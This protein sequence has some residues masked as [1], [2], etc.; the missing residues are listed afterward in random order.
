MNIFLKELHSSSDEASNCITLP[1]RRGRVS[2]ITCPRSL[3]LMKPIF[4]A[5]FTL[6]SFWIFS[7]IFLVI[8]LLP[9]FRTSRL[10]LI[11]ISNTIDLIKNK[12][13]SNRSE[14]KGNFVTPIHFSANLMSA[15]KLTSASKQFGYSGIQIM[16]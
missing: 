16:E 13:P 11:S 1:G 2:C 9:R 4:H 3:Y 5:R 14:R 7:R 8:H 10:L 6:L 12:C 15:V